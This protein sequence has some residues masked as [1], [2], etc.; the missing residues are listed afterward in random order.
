M[1]ERIPENNDQRGDQ[2]NAAGS[3]SRKYANVYQEKPF[4]EKFQS[5]LHGSLPFQSR[6]HIPQKAPGAI[7]RVLQLFLFRLLFHR[8][9][10]GLV[11]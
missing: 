10:G 8:R 11:D 7:N 6:I 3:R 4:Y 2:Q 5:A 9:F 1:A